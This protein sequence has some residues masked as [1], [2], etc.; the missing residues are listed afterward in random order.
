[1]LEYFKTSGDDYRI[2]IMPDHPT[3]L[4]VRTHTPDPVPFALYFSDGR[5]GA[6][7]VERY[8]EAAAAASGVFEVHAHRLMERMTGKIG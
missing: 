5:L 4:E 7:G 8:T 6:S 2:L 1:M 3:P